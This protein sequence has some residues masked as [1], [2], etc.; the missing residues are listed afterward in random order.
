[1]TASDAETGQFRTLTVYDTDPATVI[2]RLRELA[3]G[4][5]GCPPGAD[6]RTE[7]DEPDG[8]SEP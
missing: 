8:E 1:M 2:D 6:R 5:E 7:D 3:E 4:E